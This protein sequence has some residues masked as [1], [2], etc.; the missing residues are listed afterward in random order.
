MKTSKFLTLILAFVACIAITSC[1]Q[2]DDYTIPSS[3]G[4]D[5]NEALTAMLASATEVDL[6]YVKALYIEDGAETVPFYVENDIYVKGYVSSSDKDGNFFKEFYLQDAPSNPT[7]A[8]KII[9]DQVDTYNQYNKGREVYIS[10][11]GLQIGE[12]RVGNGIVTIGGGTEFDQYGGVV[13]RVNEN[14]IRDNIL[15][16]DVTEEI[17]PLAVT[18][19]ELTDAHVGVFVEIDGVEFADNLDGERYFDAVQVYDTQRTLQACSGF[20][21]SNMSLETSSF[22][23]FKE[24]LLPTGNGSIKAIVN[25]TFDGSTRILALNTVEDVALDGARC[26][27][28]DESDFSEIFFED[29]ESMSTFSTVSGNGW[30]AYAEEGS[31]NWRALTTTDS[32][33]PGPGNVIASMGAYNSNSPSNIAWLISPS[34][35][36]DA[37]EYEFVNFQSS[38][39][40][41]DASELQVLISTDWDGTEANITTATWTTLSDATVVDASEYYQD[42]IDSGLVDLSSYSGTAYVAFKYIGGDD[43][44]DNI[45]G[46][47]EI[48]NYKVLAE[49]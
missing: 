37:Q 6:A 19:S 25:K 24:H 5:E 17:I 49:N 21:Y 2:D 29:F 9:I 35:D 43:G 32:G 26:S 44:S 8:L 46:T 13:T 15:R 12:E 39:S 33:N 22:A 36:L 45:D 4:D 28:L 14:Q 30:T 31:Y 10:L 48:D 7:G 40:F 18:F 42:W 38:N 20:T 34:I 47:F 11:K 1:V 3:L 16:S 27:T 23:T 41:S